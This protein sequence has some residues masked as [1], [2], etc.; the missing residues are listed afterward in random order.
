MSLDKIQ[1]AVDIPAH[2][3]VLWNLIS[4][5]SS[6]SDQILYTIIS[7][8]LLWNV[9]KRLFDEDV[10][11]DIADPPNFLSQRHCLNCLLMVLVFQVD[12]N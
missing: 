8:A 7:E 1:P 5:V 3:Q 10:G 11:M 12:D 2:V 4:Q 9:F 6:R